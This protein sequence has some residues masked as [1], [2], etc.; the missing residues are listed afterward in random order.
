MQE[1]T[2][3]RHKIN[4]SFF[5]VRDVIIRSAFQRY[6]PK[7]TRSVQNLIFPKLGIPIL[8]IKNTHS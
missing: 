1:I 6:Y 2:I 5:S 8:P 7:R 4:H 3:I